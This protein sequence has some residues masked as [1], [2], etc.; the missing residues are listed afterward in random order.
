M[1]EVDHPA[2][3]AAHVG[4]ELGVSGW[5][6]VDEAMILRFAELTGDTH[7]IHTDPERARRETPFGGVIAHGYLTL[8]FATAMSAECLRVRKAARWLNGGLNQVRFT[9]PVRPEMRLRGR[10]ALKEA[11]PQGDDR[12]RLVVACIMEIEGES[13]PAMVA[14]LVKVVFSHQLETQS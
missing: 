1:T 12:M 8:S 11:T 3:L 2:E 6:K 10:F 7:W 9:Q 13:R 5:K 14:D 4:R